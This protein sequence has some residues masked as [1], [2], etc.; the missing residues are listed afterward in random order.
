MILFLAG[1]Y[2]WPSLQKHEL[3]ESE[4]T[5]KFL[6]HPIALVSCNGYLISGQVSV[7]LLLCNTIELHTIDF[8]IVR[9]SMLLWLG[10]KIRTPF[11]NG[12]HN[13]PYHMI[14]YGE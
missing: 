10:T 12:Y 11:S 13:H 9:R 1:F 6:S 8:A 4:E 7:Y 3:S 5:T 14:M 2:F